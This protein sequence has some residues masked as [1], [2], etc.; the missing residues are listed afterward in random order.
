MFSRISLVVSLFVLLLFCY[1]LSS[2]GAQP[3][4]RCLAS[5][6]TSLSEAIK[7]EH[8]DWSVVTLDVLEA[9]DRKLFLKENKGGCPGVVKVDFYGDGSKVFAIVLSKGSGIDRRSRLI[10]GRPA[11]NNQWRLT[12]LENEVKGGGPPVVFVEPA[13]EFE[14]VYNQMKKKLKSKHEAILFVG[15]ESWAIVYVWTGNSIEK[16]WMSD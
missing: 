12:T 11:G 10:I 2:N 13:G 15:Y 1:A 6:P 16:V 9:Y 5:I 14:G 4:D 7:Q 3:P 8:P